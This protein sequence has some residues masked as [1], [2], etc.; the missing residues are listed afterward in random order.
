MPQGGRAYPGH[1]LQRREITAKMAALVLQ[2]L[3]TGV[4]SSTE[5]TDFTEKRFPPAECPN[6]RFGRADA[7]NLS[8]LG[9]FD[10]DEMI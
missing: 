5:M 9:E 7:R 2:G 6:L 1:G 4:S 10:F 8:Y 3:V